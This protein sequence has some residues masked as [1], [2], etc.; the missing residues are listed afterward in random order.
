MTEGELR[1]QFSAQLRKWINKKGITPYRLG[2]EMGLGNIRAVY[3][4]LRIGIV[5]HAGN[6]A[7]ML[8]IFECTPEQFWGLK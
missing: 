3:E 5:P 1:A 6:F 2:R 7:K 8:T 4:M